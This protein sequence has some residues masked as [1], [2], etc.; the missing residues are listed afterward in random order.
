MTQQRFL[1]AVSLLARAAFMTVHRPVE[2]TL[3]IGVVIVVVIARVACLLRLLL[4]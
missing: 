1:R 2:A 3:K 4:L